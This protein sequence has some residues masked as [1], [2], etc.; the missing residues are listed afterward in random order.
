MTT[1]SGSKNVFI[2]HLN[3]VLEDIPAYVPGPT[4]ASVAE[5]VGI[6]P[7]YLVKLSSNEAPMGPSP[8]VR[9]ALRDVAAGDEIHRYPSPDMRDLREA[10]AASIDL[11]ADQILPADGSSETW[12][13]I[14]R[15]FSRPG[16][17]VMTIEPS[18]RSYQQLAVVSERVP[19]VVRLEAPFEL[20]ADQIVL[21]LTPVTRVLFLS[22]PN[23]TTSRALK[24]D[25]IR[26]IADAASDCVVV[27]DE[28]YIEA[29]PD[30]RERT[31][32][33]L[34]GEVSNIVVTRT[35]SK[36]YGL[37]GMRVGYAA[38]SLDAI[39]AIRKVRSLWAVSLPAKAA[40]IAAVTD[41]DHLKR[42]IET[43]ADGR[44]QLLQ[45]LSAWAEVEISPAPEGGFI[46]LR[47]GDL[48]GPDVA[49]AVLKDGVMVRGDLADEYIRVSVGTRA[50]NTR[51]L[52]ALE[53]VVLGLRK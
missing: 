13:A 39:A 22:T 40:A 15:A 49:E 52:T 21:N 35:F 51:F 14:V 41:E 6:A 27:V 10:I 48:S 2:E 3:P 37:A 50:Q 43:T 23:N 53:Q 32:I 44:R 18:L 29:V 20:T 7:R 25:T 28:H 19:Q 4:A 34:V 45:G 33:Q 36:M 5:T 24:L 8:S 17:G 42:N 46:L 16:E 38:S 26:E 47:V 30:Y 11:D 31:A 9:D 12:P 1:L